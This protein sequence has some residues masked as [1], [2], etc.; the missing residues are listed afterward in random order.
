M[1]VFQ[2]L[3]VS[4]LKIDNLV[5]EAP[6]NDG[7]VARLIDNVSLQLAKG[8]VLGL[9]GESGAGK[10]TLGLAALGVLRGNQRATEGQVWLDGAQLGHLGTRGLRALRGRKVAYV[11]QSAASAFNPAQRLIDQVIETAV[12]DD[13]MTSMQARERAIDLFTRLGLPDPKNFGNKFPHQASGGQLQRAMTAM[14]MCARPE[15]IVFDEPTTALDVTTQIEVLVAIRQAIRDEH[16][17]ALYI[18]HDL[19]LVAQM[20][21]HIMVL[22]HGRMV[23]HGSARQI[24]D[25]PQSP[26]TQAL[27]GARG[28]QHVPNLPSA[29]VLEITGLDVAYGTLRVINGLSTNVPKGG[30]LAVIGESGSGKSTLGRAICGLLPW[31]AGS[32]RF[33][34]REL[35][36]DLRRR[37]RSDLKDIQLIHQLPD[38]ALNPRQTVGAAIGAALARWRGLRGAAAKAETVHLL[39]QVELD[40]D[41][42]DRLPAALSG[43]QKQRGCIARALAAQPRLIVC[44]EVTSALDPLVAEGVLK[45]LTRLQRETGTSYLFITHDFGAVNAIADEVAVLRQGELVANGP[46]AQV[47]SPPMAPYTLALLEAVPK[48]EHGWLD[49]IAARNIQKKTGK[50]DH[51]K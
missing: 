1:T 30:T 3:D 48:L 42:A 46:I 35:A 36:P 51:G 11:A 31:T 45:L 28:V 4:L 10:S 14:A 2:E 12:C 15:L 27:I 32:I 24:I 16:M 49:Q 44:D 19:A 17:A 41:L 40:P 37:K 43:G 13:L 21:D 6:R 18:S 20:A 29:A 22:R 39:S 38:L 50:T 47:F 34:G 33:E 25:T 26:Y 8:Q 9:I 5:I 7:S 23:E